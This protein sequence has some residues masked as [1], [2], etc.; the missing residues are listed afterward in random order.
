MLKDDLI[1]YIKNLNDNIKYDW[2]N[3]YQDFEIKASI[4]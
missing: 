2:V 3:A 4:K 1:E